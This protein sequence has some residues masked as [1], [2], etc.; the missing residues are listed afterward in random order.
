MKWLLRVVRATDAA[1]PSPEPSEPKSELAKLRALFRTAFS[2]APIGMAI[3]DQSERVMIANDAL[4]GIVGHSAEELIGRRLHDLVEP[5]DREI[6]AEDRRRLLAGEL[7]QYVA[8]LRLRRADG[9]TVWVRLT[10]AGDD[11][12]PLSVIYQMEDITERQ[13]LQDQLEYVIDHDLL[14]G[15]FNRR[16][17]DQELDREL[18]RH[19]RLGQGGAVLI[20]DLDGFKAVNDE[21]GHA[22]GDQLLRGISAKLKERSRAS[23]VLARLSGDEFALLLPEA[24]REVAELVA[25]K[26]VR[27]VA[28]HHVAVGSERA[29]VTASIGVALFEG[30]DDLELLALADAAM[31]S[32]KAAGRNRFVVF[33]PNE[34]NPLSS[35]RFAEANQ[36]RRALREESFVLYCQPICSLAQ[37]RRIEHYELLI[38]MR[39]DSPGALI[40]PNAFL[41]AAER[42]GLIA[43]IDAWVVAQAV[44]LIAEQGRR[45]HRVVLAV[46][47]SGRSIGD[48]ALAAHVD[49]LLNE[50]GIEP[51]C[52]IF[53]LTETA[54]IANV[55]T[56]RT[57]IERLRRRGCS[58]ALDDFGAGFASFYYLKTLPFDFVKI[59][60]TFVQGLTTSL[61]D[62]LVIA[63]IVDVARGMGKQTIAE[64]VGDQP[65]SDLLQANGVDYVQGFHIAVP[66][67]VEDV[68]GEQELVLTP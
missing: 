59:D 52:L 65:T 22:A 12:T 36:L 28:R 61:T 21:F 6:D 32:A 18:E 13:R 67:P 3:V 31:Y 57:F 64:W 51:S 58:F 23:D 46:N 33:D 26:L 4:G 25:G 30:L 35:D 8:E 45:G 19:A 40:A 29:H 49:R 55:E 39:G 2:N 16:R 20:M 44:E 68:L 56:A 15:L 41:Y 53:E 60:G 5:E 50:S 47:L 43:E 10:A 66:R 14:T 7:S 24:T 17:F 34:E 11:E 38:R 42:F 54:A 27:L 9:N 48:P 1:V 62:Q 37:Q 63:A